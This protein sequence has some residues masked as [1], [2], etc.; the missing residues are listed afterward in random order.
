M[1]NS[2]VGKTME[3]MRKQTCNN[4]KKKKLFGVRTKLS[5]NIFFH[6]N[7]AVKIKK[8]QILMNK[9]VYLGLQILELS[10]TVMYELWYD[11]VKIKYEE[12]AKLC[13]LDTDGFIV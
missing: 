6:E 11:Y 3:N 2:V 5:N 1:N 9:P 7:L 13:Y 12:N 8:I 4:R 10:K